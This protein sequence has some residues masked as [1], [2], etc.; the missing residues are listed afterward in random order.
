LKVERVS[1]RAYARIADGDSIYDGWG[2]NQ[3]FVTTIE[4][5]A[6]VDTGFT[7]GSATS[8]L[9]EVRKESPAPVRFVVNTHDH[10]DHV[11]GNSIFDEIS[12]AIIAHA[13]C[14][15]R[16]IEMGTERISGYRRFDATLRSA[17]KG[18]RICPPRITYQEEIDFTLGETTLRLLHPGKGAHTS[19]DT[20]VYLPDEKV[21]FAGDV[22]W[23]GYHPNLEDADIGGWLRALGGISKMSVDH[24]VPGHGP[25]AGKSSVAPLAKYLR[26][27]DAS[28]KRL[29]REGV[30]KERIAEELVMEGTE[31]WR[32]KMIV[33]RNVSVLY[34]RY[35]GRIREA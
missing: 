11:F 23:V 18:L 22:L 12:P 28:F 1:R 35:R 21:L 16:L 25:V 24:I 2:A 17:L 29:V 26:N 20:M 33:E 10:S 15:A 5:A 14:R 30:P 13:N 32:L 19:G 6:V 3:G 8:L 27:F 4:G 9:R 31:E 34:E 7:F